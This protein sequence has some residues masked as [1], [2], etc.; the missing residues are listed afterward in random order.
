MK[1]W[2]AAHIPMYL[3][4]SPGA[5]LNALQ[6]SE[7]PKCILKSSSMSYEAKGSCVWPLH[8]S[9][10]LVDLSEKHFH[11]FAKP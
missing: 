8:V 5:F 9:E 6:F 3:R 10:G 1:H 2:E 4:S 7:K 11:F